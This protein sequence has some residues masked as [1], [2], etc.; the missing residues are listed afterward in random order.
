M[1]KKRITK[2]ISFNSQKGGVNK[3]TLSQ[4]TV[5]EA[6]N[7]KIK[8]LLADCDPKQ[9]TS[10]Y[11]SNDRKK[12]GIKPIVDCRVFNTIEEVF[13]T[14]LSNYNLVVIDAPALA[15]AGT[16]LAAEKSDI[17]VQPCGASKA[18]LRPA[19]K[20]FRS[21]IDYGI[22]ND[23]LFIVLS[24]IGTP[25]EA[26]DAKQ[27]FS[28]EAVA[29]NEIKL[30]VLDNY[31]KEMPSYRQITNQG[32]SITEINF[33]SLQTEALNVIQEIVDKAYGRNEKGE[34]K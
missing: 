31:L 2:Y 22:P 25:A 15:T 24:K 9:R 19:I 16:K 32:K 26:R 1:N 23:K 14:D 4:A 10:F 20:V 27:Y 34:N 3:S 12:A 6:E 17:V 18:D 33:V 28:E 8:T 30:N 13:S 5:V 7:A 21:L 11:W 29:R